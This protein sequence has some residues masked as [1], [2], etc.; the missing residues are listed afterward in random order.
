MT[1]GSYAVGYRLF[2]DKYY[3]RIFNDVGIVGAFACLHN[4]VSEFVYDPVGPVQGFAIKKENFLHLLKHR[5][6]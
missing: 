2:N 5:M 3:C 6:G 1:K 4:K